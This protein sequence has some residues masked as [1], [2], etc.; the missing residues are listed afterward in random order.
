MRIPTLRT[1][2]TRRRG[3]IPTVGFALFCVL[4]LALQESPLFGSAPARSTSSPE[5]TSASPPAPS[6]ASGPVLRLDPRGEKVMLRLEKGTDGDSFVGITRAQESV[7]VRLIGIDA[8]ERA[9]PHGPQA[10]KALEEKL[11]RAE[12]EVTLVRRDNYGRWL[13][14]ARIDGNDV[15][16]WMLREGHAW[17]YRE[18]LK[19]IP[20]GVREPYDRAEAAARSAQRGLWALPS[21]EAPWDFRRRRRDS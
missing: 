16:E 11:R 15:G 13:V 6:Q 2:P 18:Y 17:M 21:P 12:F 10:R 5:A 9:Q 14:T 20:A 8:P 4:M 19:D 3:L 1:L 7:R